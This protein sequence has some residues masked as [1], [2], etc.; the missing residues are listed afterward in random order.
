MIP[1]YLNLTGLP[2]ILFVFVPEYFYPING[3]DPRYQHYFLLSLTAW[4][5]TVGPK[6]SL[7][8]SIRDIFIAEEKPVQKKETELTNVK[9]SEEKASLL[10]K[11]KK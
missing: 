5:L 2:F 3:K 11:K 1:L 7:Y 9:E 8:K 6:E 4:F 10:N